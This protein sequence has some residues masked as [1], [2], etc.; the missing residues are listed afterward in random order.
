MGGLD[1]YGGKQAA[2]IKAA[3]IRAVRRVNIG[4]S[5]SVWVLRRV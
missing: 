1:G 4:L 2:A 5:S 3:P